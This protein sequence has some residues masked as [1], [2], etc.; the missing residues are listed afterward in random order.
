MAESHK[1]SVCMATYNGGRY[2][3]TQLNSILCQLGENDE[4]IVSDD[5]S[6]DNTLDVVESIGDNRIK[7][8]KNETPHGVVGNFNNAINHSSGDIIF[9]SD[10]DDIWMENKVQMCLAAL[11]DND[12]VV[13]NALLSD[14]YGRS[15]GRDY[16]S[17]Y[18][19]STSFWNN[20]WKC[21]FLGSCMAFRR[22]SL[23]QLM[24]CPNH[25]IILHDYWLFMSMAF[26]HKRIAILYP[27]LIRYRRH[28]GTATR[29]GEKNQTSLKF[30]LVK[31]FGLLQL[32]LKRY[33]F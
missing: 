22:G 14:Q 18:H 25:S 13:H 30:K 24:P 17:L 32:L 8:V 21:A 5:G 1:L 31:R 11:K 9:L 10:Q 29:S 20:W 7:V 23:M 4:I 27:P 19:V 26:K 16:F 12:M 2:I 28:G 33:V 15:L 6:K 3:K